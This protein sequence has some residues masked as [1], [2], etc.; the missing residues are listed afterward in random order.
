MARAGGESGEGLPTLKE[1]QLLPQV[2]EEEG[3]GQPCLKAHG[4]SDGGGSPPPCV[5][6]LDIKYL[7]HCPSKSLN[8]FHSMKGKQRRSPSL[9]A[10]AR[11][12]IKKNIYYGFELRPGSGCQRELEGEIGE[13]IL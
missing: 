1:Q 10:N 2:P 6:F 7:V 11:L 4:D 9:N 8:D 3:T 13:C 12:C 5:L